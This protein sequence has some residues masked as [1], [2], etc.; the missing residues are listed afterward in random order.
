ME[1]LAVHII[2]NS[3][4]LSDKAVAYF[5]TVK[6]PGSKFILDSCV[7]GAWG[8]T[9]YPAAIFYQPNPPRGRPECTNY[10]G[11]VIKGSQMFIC[12]AIDIT[13]VRIDAVVADDGDVIWSRYRH[14]YRESNDG[15]VWID[16]GRDYT[17]SGVFDPHPKGFPRF[18]SLIVDRD[19][20]R[21]A[22]EAEVSWPFQL[23]PPDTTYTEA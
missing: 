16:G 7:K 14:D 4:V 15:S 5:E 21:F 3:D 9:D 22:T 19:Q 13:T 8:W 1:G 20:L 12:Q 6:Y 11:I 18:V 2:K 10:F 17:R 23:T